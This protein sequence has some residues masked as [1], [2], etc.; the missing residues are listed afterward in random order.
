VTRSGSHK[1]A[2]EKRVRTGSK[3]VQE[4]GEGLGARLEHARAGERPLFLPDLPYF[5]FFPLPLSGEIAG[6]G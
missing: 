3:E 1:A 5:L 4:G 6:T 2:K